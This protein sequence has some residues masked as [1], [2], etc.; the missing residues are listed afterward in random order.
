MG[1]QDEDLWGSDPEVDELTAI[2]LFEVEHRR[3]LA[4]QALYHRRSRTEGAA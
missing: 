4:M 2:A 1:A 3:I